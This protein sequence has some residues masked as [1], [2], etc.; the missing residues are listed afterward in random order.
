MPTVF[1]PGIGRDDA[2]ARHPQGDRQVV[3]QAGDLAQPQPCLEL[4]LE[5]GDH[6]AGLDLDDADIEAELLEGLLQDL[7][8]AADLVL[9]LVEVEGLA[10]QQELDARQ[11]VV[12]GVLRRLVELQVLVLLGSLGLADPQERRQAAARFGC[13]S[14]SG[15]LGRLIGLL[16]G[17]N[18][19]RI[20]GLR[21]GLFTGTSLDADGEDLG[22]AASFF[23]GG[24]IA[25]E[26]RLAAEVFGRGGADLPHALPDAFSRL[27]D[28]KGQDMHEEIIGGKEDPAEDQAG[29]EDIRADRGEVHFQQTAPGR[30]EVAAGADHRPGRELRHGHGGEG[31]QPCQR[32]QPAAEPRDGLRQ[33][34]A[35]QQHGI[36]HAE[37]K[38]EVVGPQSQGG[39]EVAA[40]EGPR[41]SA[42]VQHVRA[43]GI[44]ELAGRIAG[45]V[46]HQR[47][48]QEHGQRKQAEGQQV[49]F[50]ITLYEHETR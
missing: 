2:D 39:E 14:V 30:A 26:V 13:G 40:D 20:G 27:A 22:P 31:R 25:I 8:L 36:E 5:L 37:R 23:F 10:G 4:D 15:G 21:L 32:D 29:S 50:Q 11:F 3:G 17:H 12:G 45:I 16:L 42:D 34:P 28:D 9:L 43:L 49:L 44:D 18:G 19:R 41:A 24:L 48:R 38:Y 47:S 46:A 33:R 35:G 1:L 7:G 6:R